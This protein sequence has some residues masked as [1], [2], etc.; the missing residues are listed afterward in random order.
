[1]LILANY[2]VPN[3]DQLCRM[4]SIYATH[5]SAATHKCKCHRHLF[6]PIA[7]AHKAVDCVKLNKWTLHQTEC[8]TIHVQIALH[9]ICFNMV[10]SRRKS[11]SLGSSGRKAF[12][13]LFTYAVI[14]LVDPSPDRCI[15]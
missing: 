15:I 14:F 9:K 7:M 6:L 11:K 4:Y 1:M 13:V 10:K 8:L 5:L 2:N 12:L 3:S